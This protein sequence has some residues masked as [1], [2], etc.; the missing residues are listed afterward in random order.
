MR[1][2]LI[3][4]LWQFVV[5]VE[6][7]IK[8]MSALMK[9]LKFAALVNKK[10]AVVYTVVRNSRKYLSYFEHW[11]QWSQMIRPQLCAIENTLYTPCTMDGVY[12]T[13]IPCCTQHHKM[14]IRT[15][16]WCC[17]F[18]FS[19]WNYEFKPDT[20]PKTEAERVA[21]AKKYNMLPEEYKPYP[22]DG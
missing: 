3:A 15:S 18:I 4:Q 19:D 22:E 21:A 10:S 12:V 8:I 2:R 11:L 16:Y 1:L 5:V 13:K 9:T 17:L 7:S 14:L 6:P 20:W